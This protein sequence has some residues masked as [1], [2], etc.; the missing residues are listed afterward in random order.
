MSA[1]QD[2]P[3]TQVGQRRWR[4][5][6]VETSLACGQACLMCP[7]KEI[8]RKAPNNGLMTEATWE[9]ILPHLDQ[10]ALIDLS[11]GG[12]PLVHPRLLDWLDQARDRGC[13]T[14]FLTNGLLL[15]GAAAERLAAGAD[16][17]AF[18][19]HGATREVYE[20]IVVGGQFEVLLANVERLSRLRRAG[21][22]RLIFQVVMLPGNVHQLEALVRLAADLGVDQ[23]N[24][25]HCDV[26]RQ[27]ELRD[28]ALFLP[29]GSGQVR[30]HQKALARARRL[31]RRLGVAFTAFS[32]EPDEMPVC[33]MDPRDALFVAADGRVTPCV[34]L[35]YGGPADFLGRPVEMPAVSFGRLPGEDLLDIWNNSPNCRLFRE[36]FSQRIRAYNAALAAADLGEPSLPR[37]QAALEEARR[38]MPPPPPGCRV[39]HYL[40]DL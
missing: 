2:D 32:F 25:K 13:R 34:S 28:L 17:V 24:F 36:C 3:A 37:L 1:A 8:R 27:S 4:F 33:D 21:R 26:I 14:G 23:I 15:D 31:A 10:V 18:S 5:L 35:A 6:Q 7:W 16:W 9:A 11:G 29:A 22:P 20:K 30:R 38:A 19:I 39:C 12:E 40:Y